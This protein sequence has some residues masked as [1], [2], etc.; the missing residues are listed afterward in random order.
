MTVLGAV[1]SW[2]LFLWPVRG[3]SSFL[4]GW[5]PNTWNPVK[6]IA[7]S[8][9]IITALNWA[10]SDTFFYLQSW[11]QT[12]SFPG[13]TPLSFSRWRPGAEKTLGHAS[14]ILHESWSILSRET[15]GTRLENRLHVSWINKVK[16]WFRA[17]GAYLF[18]FWTPS[19]LLQS[20]ASHISNYLLTLKKFSTLYLHQW[21]NCNFSLP[22]NNN[23]GIPF[24]SF[25][26]TMGCQ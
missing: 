23:T 11:K 7:P 24:G 15:L 9:E 1:M 19:L 2:C 8:R 10:Q 18:K 17:W 21:L 26:D 3:L 25:S 12:T 16:I 4:Q 22:L 14:E 6:T 13:S 20:S 5:T